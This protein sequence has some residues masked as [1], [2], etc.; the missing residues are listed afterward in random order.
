MLLIISIMNLRYQRGGGGG[1]DG[2][3][4]KGRVNT[5]MNTIKHNETYICAYT[6]GH[7]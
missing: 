3:E 2:G 7:I 1:G 4:R 5:V 6:Q